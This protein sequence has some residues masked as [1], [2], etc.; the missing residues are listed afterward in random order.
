MGDLNHYIGGD[1]FL[2]PTGDLA[3]TSG[4]IEGRQRVL[5]RLLTNAGDYIWH[6]T[7]GANLPGEVGS[8]ADPRRITGI[9]RSQI[10]N[11]AAVSISPDPR[12]TVTAIN[13]GVSAHIQYVDSTTKQQVGLAFDVNR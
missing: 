9:V 2:S 7:Y 3:V 13:G 10:L 12:I 5:R 4:S 6:T 11:E 1:L 8:L